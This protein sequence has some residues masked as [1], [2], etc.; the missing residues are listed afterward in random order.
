MDLKEVLLYQLGVA[1]WKVPEA[2]HPPSGRVGAA[3]EGNHGGGQPRAP[4]AT[5]SILSSTTLTFGC[6]HG[7]SAS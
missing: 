5:A 3:G 1:L 6:G 4:T 7:S 2:L